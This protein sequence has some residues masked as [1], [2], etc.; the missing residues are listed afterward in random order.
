MSN[1]NRKHQA[2]FQAALKT[3]SSVGFSQA[4]MD[5][6]AK[7]AQVSKATLYKYFSGKEEILKT[8]LLRFLEGQ[9]VRTLP[10]PTQ[11]AEFESYLVTY[12]EKKI[13]LLTQDE[14]LMFGRVFYAELIQSKK[15]AEEIQSEYGEILQ[16]GLHRVLKHG[17]ALS[18]LKEHDSYFAVDLFYGVIK[19]L[20]FWP[21]M[22]HVLSKEQIQAR[23]TAAAKAA[24][25]ALLEF[26]RNP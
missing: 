13:E 7:E 20:I 6:V 11:K 25:Q 23:K 15:L 22:F 14:N 16:E 12:G 18:E 3:F 21:M 1:G 24:T 8:M 26:C 4:S 19:G 5:L 9:V 10:L 2:I 17:V